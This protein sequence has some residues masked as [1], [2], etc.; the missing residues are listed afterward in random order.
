[1]TRSTTLTNCLGGGTMMNAAL[2][3]FDSFHGLHRHDYY[4]FQ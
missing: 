2:A 3:M 1:M 4:I